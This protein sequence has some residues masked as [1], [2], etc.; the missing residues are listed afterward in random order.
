MND[1]RLGL[2]ITIPA[3]PENVAVIRHAVAGLAE[4]LGMREPAVGDLKTVVTEACMNVVVHAYEG[5]PGPLQVE[6]HAEGGGVTVAVRD[7]G[8]GIRPNADDE[9]QSLRIGLTL[10]AALSSSFSISGGLG[11]GT[12]VTMH[13]LLDPAA[14]DGEVTDA[15]EVPAAPEEAELQIDGRAIVAPVLER[16]IGA[17]A[18]RHPIGIDRLNDV[19]LLADAVSDGAPQVLDEGPYRFAVGD[20]DGGIDIRVGP[21]PAGASERLRDGL[22]LP[23]VGGSLENLADTVA[24]EEGEAGEYLVVRFFGVAQG[25]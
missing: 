21:L 14:A 19:F 20:G 8:R 2:L 22:S 3:K 24:V 6:A 23:E 12:E 16:V 10:I 9:R 1:D 5:E 15:S 4:Q 25:A 18:A 11:K 13:L 17:L 7:F